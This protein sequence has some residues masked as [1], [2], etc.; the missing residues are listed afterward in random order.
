MDMNALPTIDPTALGDNVPRR[1]GKIA[2]RLARAFL[3]KTGWRITG[4]I[5]NVSQ[6]VL[7][8]V[9][10]TSNMDGVYAI[11][12]LL[13]LDVNIKLLGKKQLFKLP[14][15]S[16]FLTWAGVI[17]IDRDKKGSVLQANIDRFKTGKPL[18]LGLA[19]EGTRG[20]TDEW[21]TGFYYLAVGAGVPILPVAMDY[22]TKEVRFMPL[23]YPTGDIEKDLPKIYA[24]YNGVEGR[25]VGKM[26]K[27]LQDLSK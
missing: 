9:P 14:I 12:T 21:K 27:P 15:M 4:E 7:L 26:S 6:A 18:F 23:F 20:Y 10:H 24:Y 17:P 3:D 8:A 25:H 2:P 22:K 5:P 19:P 16:H 1:H 13:A 11:P